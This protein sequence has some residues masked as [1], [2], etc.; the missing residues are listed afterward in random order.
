MAKVKKSAVNPQSRP[1]ADQVIPIPEYTATSFPFGE[2]VESNPIGVG[3][4]GYLDAAGGI[5]ASMANLTEPPIGVC[6]GSEDGNVVMATSGV[7]DVYCRQSGNENSSVNQISV[8][9]YVG[10]A[11]D[12]QSYGAVAVSA[13]GRWYVGKAVTASNSETGLVKVLIN[14]GQIPTSS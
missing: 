8:G 3:L 12:S 1:R 4:I 2:S 5:V 7:C 9:D 6:I 11:S 10:A 14:P 13:A